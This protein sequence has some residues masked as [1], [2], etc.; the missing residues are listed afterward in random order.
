MR[1][2]HWERKD[3]RISVLA[4]KFACRLDLALT[5]PYE[6]VVLACTRQ[7]VCAAA[8]LPREW[9]RV[10]A[11]PPPPL[12]AALTRLRAFVACAFWASWQ[13]VLATIG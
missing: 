1:A 13:N 8:L 10:G 2:V 3:T 11:R 5:W 7:V 12:L 6:G 4:Y 9:A